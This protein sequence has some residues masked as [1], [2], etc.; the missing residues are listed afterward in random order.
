MSELQSLT[1]IAVSARRPLAAAIVGLALLGGVMSL[2]AQSEDVKP[3]VES[4]YKDIEQAFGKVPGFI[5]AF[6]AAGVTGA[7]NEAKGMLFSG[8]TALTVKE[9]SLISL[10][11][12][13]QIPCQYC[14]WSDTNDAR[15]A[16]A[17]EEEIAEAVT[18]AALARHWST[19]LNGM[20]V[21]FAEFKAD[22]GGDVAPN[23]AK[24]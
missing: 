24:K 17:T 11:V 22:L 5:K 2:P 14:V 8:D 20:Q 6:P 15:R 16:G 7:W 12:S 18:V 1:R 10:A 19:W 23:M 13:A 4:T 3:A 21:D 9:K